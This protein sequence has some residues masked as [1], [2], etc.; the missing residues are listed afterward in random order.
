MRSKVL[1]LIVLLSFADNNSVAKL[2]LPN[3]PPEFIIG[4]IN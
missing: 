4:P 3:L 1:L 2:D